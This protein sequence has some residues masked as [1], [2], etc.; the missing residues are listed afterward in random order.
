MSSLQHRFSGLPSHQV[1]STP[2]VDNPLRYSMLKVTPKP[3]TPLMA[4]AKGECQCDACLQGICPGCG[5]MRFIH[6]KDGGCMYRMGR[7]LGVGMDAGGDCPCLL[8]PD[9]SQQ[10]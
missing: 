5:H 3:I 10:A 4:H 2:S 9:D 1:A 6:R 7:D 8:G